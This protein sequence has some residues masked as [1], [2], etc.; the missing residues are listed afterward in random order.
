MT[1]LETAFTE[2][3]VDAI[4]TH[5]VGETTMRR[6]WVKVPDGWRSPQNR[7]WVR[8]ERLNKALGGTWSSTFDRAEQTETI[9]I[10][11]NWLPEK[12]EGTRLEIEADELLQVVRSVEMVTS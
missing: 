12:F 9:Q 7:L 6:V 10:K 4:V 5:H 11:A 8:V 1:D 2:W 3:A